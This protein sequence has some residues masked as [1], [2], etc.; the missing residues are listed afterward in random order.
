MGGFGAWDLIT[1][2]PERFEVTAP[3]CGGGDEP[4]ATRA[5]QVPVWAFHS[6]DDGVV[7][8]SRTRNMI[9]TLRAAG[10]QPKYF[11][12]WGLGHNCWDKAY[13]EPEF[14]PWMFAQRLGQPDTYVLKS[15]PPE[16]PA[17]G[18]PA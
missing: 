11:E 4:V 13:A 2:F 10:G 9:A 3:V 1:R 7:K 8:V 15:K 5:T 16:V 6:D 12:Y 14:L 18:R 17:M